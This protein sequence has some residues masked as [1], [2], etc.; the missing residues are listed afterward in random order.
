MGPFLYFTASFLDAKSAD[1]N[2]DGRLLSGNDFLP[3]LY[4]VVF[5]TLPQYLYVAAMGIAISLILKGLFKLNWKK[6]LNSRIFTREGWK[7]D[8]PEKKR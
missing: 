1:H 4:S 8:K 6:V 3:K 7:R 2:D 5:L